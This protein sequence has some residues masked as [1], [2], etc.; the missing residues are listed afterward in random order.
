[1][2]AEN[3]SK[4]EHLQHGSIS[5]S[6][7]TEKSPEN[8]RGTVIIHGEGHQRVIKDYPHIF[9]IYRLYEGIRRFFGSEYF[10]VEE[11]LDGYNV[12]I[13][14]NGDDIIAVTR[15]GIICPFTTEWVRYWRNIHRL[16]EFFS[17]YPDKIICAEFVGDNPYNSKR[18]P[19][20]PAGLS[21]F[22]F[23]IMN[24]DGKLIP[25]DE[26][27]EIFSRLDLPRVKSFGKFRLKDYS[28]LRDV[29]LGLNS[30]K[31]EG[32]V[33][34]GMDGNRS[35]KFVTAE[36][37]LIDIEKNLAYFYDIEPGFYS[38]RLMRIALFIQE[39]NLDEA[40]YTAKIGKALFYG[41]S[42]LNNYDGSVEN[43][44]IY[45]HSM[46]N[47]KELKKLIIL[48]KD[49]VYDGIE[50]AEIGGMKLHKIVFGRKHKKST[51][52]YREILGGHE[53]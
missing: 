53:E 43:F 19:A 8:E 30:K 41:Y 48:H 7:Y 46:E 10:Y 42:F 17:L 13:V 33:L 24:N 18:D 11:K 1:M 47:W 5:Y 36:S 44:T 45:M 34:K 39:F 50:P 2:K 20:L 3:Q 9:R 51:E 28:G 14:K 21:Y 23:D 27:Y 49:I 31:R 26:K 12:R 40:E 29:M 22:C 52:R 32:I 4:I 15:G 37:D 38:N 6:R 35:I 16:D 25:V